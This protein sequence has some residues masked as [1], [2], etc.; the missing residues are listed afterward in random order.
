MQK[1]V[2][3]DSDLYARGAAAGSREGNHVDNYINELI[4]LQLREAGRMYQVD[5]A[6]DEIAIEGDP[7]GSAEGR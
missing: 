5:R 3:I 1:P 6:L 2:Q 7:L 4:R